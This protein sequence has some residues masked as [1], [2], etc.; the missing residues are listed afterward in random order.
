MTAL[1][2]RLALCASIVL[3]AAVG[4]ATSAAPAQAAT[5]TF[6]YT[7]SPSDP[8]ASR[9]GGSATPC[10]L[11]AVGVDVHHS[12][13]LVTVDVSGGYLGSDLY[14]SGG[15]GLIA[16]YD[17]P[18]DPA[19][20]TAG[21]VGS[22]DD[23]SFGTAV[24]LEAGTT[25]VLFQSTYYAGST[26]E[27]G[28]EIT[29]PGTLSVVSAAAA[30]TSTTVTSDAGTVTLPTAAV[31]TATVTGTSPT[32]TVEFRD[33]SSSLGTAPVVAGVATLS[34]VLPPGV[35]SIT[36]SYA[37]DAGN[38][39]STSPP[40]LQTVLPGSTATTVSVTSEANPVT[41]PAATV[42]TATVS[43][44]SPTGTVELFDGTT[45][46]GIA[47][48][49]DGVASSSV[50]L[51]PGVH[52]ITASYAGDAAN[53][54]STSPPYLQ[55]VL[56]ALAPSTT[57]IA[58]GA[59]PIT[60]PAAT[61]LTVTVAGDSP[62]GTVEV[63][64]GTI[65]L[66]TV[67]L[68]DGSATLSVT[69]PVGS[70]AITAVYPGDDRNA[71]STSATLVQVVS[72]AAA[73]TEPTTEAPTPGAPA[74]GSLAPG[75]PAPQA[76]AVPTPGAAAP[77]PRTPTAPVVRGSSVATLPATGADPVPP[78]ALGLLLLAAGGACVLVRS[79]RRASST[80]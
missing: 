74:P 11:P 76:S 5:T 64:D 2:R 73:P 27:F 78:G 61:V 6:T 10:A 79:R 41:A 52:S 80:A 22:I 21:C 34:A 60:T 38:A 66:G 35:R 31:L 18:F 56:A 49:V 24:M 30:P 67:A 1:L 7:V 37:G 46:L 40:Y 65:P 45:S 72:A 29:G 13:A 47:D 75:S 20:P 28:F 23:A 68:V 57:S 48:V 17:A 36:A 58:S 15:D 26:G 71:A 12:T 51:Q 3:L 62:T 54:P 19:D 25:Y 39:P 53:A 32:G 8:V 14:L 33:G 69:L 77:T 50:A 55:T 16:F 9:V 4:L 70:H 63:L 59:N 43:G 42:L 44:A